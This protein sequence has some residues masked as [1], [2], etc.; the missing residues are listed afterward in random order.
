[1]SSY[2]QIITNELVLRAR[3]SNVVLKIVFEPGTS[4]FH[5]GN[6]RISATPP[7]TREQAKNNFVRL[8]GLYKTSDLLS[9]N[10]PQQVKDD[11]REVD[12]NL[13]AIFGHLQNISVR[14]DAIAEEI[15]RQ[16]E[17]L[18]HVNTIA[19]SAQERIENANARID[20]KLHH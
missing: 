3:D 20:R 17:A 9:T 15:D 1:M 18:G 2:L 5:Y 4:R 10:A 13:D 8:E 7:I 11:L 14:T 19:H 12:D 16:N 6:P